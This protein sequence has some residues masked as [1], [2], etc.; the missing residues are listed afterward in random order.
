MWFVNVMSVQYFKRERGGIS[1]ASWVQPFIY[2]DPPKAVFTR[3]KER[4]NIADVKYMVEADA[5][6]GD[7]TRINEGIQMYARGQNPMVEVS[8]QNAGGGSMNSSI[9]N[10]QVSN[11]YK[12]D[13]FRPPINPI[14][15][16]VPISN[17]RIHQNYSI[18]TNPTVY[19]QTIAGEYD[20]SKVRLMTAGY[21]NPAG[22]VRSN[23][24]VQ[25]QKNQERYADK[26]AKDL[27]ALLKATASAKP[28]IGIDKT[29]DVTNK[30]LNEVKDSL[31]TSVV[32]TKSFKMDKTRDVTSKLVNEV[33]DALVTSVVPTKT[34]KMDKTRD[35]SRKY[36]TETREDPLHTSVQGAWS[37]KVDTTRDNVHKYLSETKDAMN[38][39][40]TPAWS[41][42]ID[43]T[44]D[45]SSKYITETKDLLQIAATSPITFTDVVV[46]DPRTNTSVQV[47]AN[48]REKN[49][50]SVTAAAGAPLVFNTNDGKEIK[51]KDYDYKVVTAP[52]GNTQMV[53]YVRQPEVTLD[54][55]SPLYAVQTNIMLQG[56]DHSVNREAASKMTLESLMP[57]VS[58]TSS[59]KLSN[60]D[61]GAYRASNDPNKWNLTVN[62]P[63]VSGTT[64]VT[65]KA[66]GY[67]DELARDGKVKELTK[68]SGFGSFMDRVAK[69]NFTIRGGV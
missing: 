50:V 59:V 56:V 13:A 14:E 3:K 29:R 34:F 68:L 42:S 40:V 35:A 19:P 39:A 7:P 46:Y 18:T 4:V 6:G 55:H 9:H 43:T 53:I 10:G 52:A 22:N 48:I 62:V 47:E 61:E 21:S 58:A 65:L 37:F 63:L 15:L 64:N 69:P 45:T 36:I 60:Y 17:P 67:N 25:I 1:P 11:P 8:Y 41:Y 26:L 20:K 49:A 51:L 5:Q 38:L 30:S 27:N 12:I 16:Q 33:K 31:L 28:T 57:T 24:N 32:P 2:K 66:Q 54:R 44:R 23:I